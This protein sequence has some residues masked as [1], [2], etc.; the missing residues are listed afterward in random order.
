MRGPRLGRRSGMLRVPGRLSPFGRFPLISTSRKYGRISPQIRSIK[1]WSATRMSAL[2]RPMRV[3]RPP[4]MMIAV[5]SCLRRHRCLSQS[6]L[7]SATSKSPL[8]PSK[9]TVRSAC[10]ARAAAEGLGGHWTRVASRNTPGTQYARKLVDSHTIAGRGPIRSSR[11]SNA[12][13][14]WLRLARSQKDRVAPAAFI[15]AVSFGT[16]PPFSAWSSA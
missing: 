3:L 12:G 7:R 10:S 15:L 1:V 11:D 2:L 14:S 4:A 8:R 13:T 5:A 16:C 6:K 9:M